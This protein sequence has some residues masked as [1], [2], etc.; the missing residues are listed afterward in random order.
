MEISRWSF[1]VGESLGNDSWIADDILRD[2]VT[3][4]FCI[5]AI[6]RGG[7][8]IMKSLRIKLTITIL[9]VFFIALSALGGLNYWK[10]RQL[11]MESMQENLMNQTV[12][13]ADQLGLWIGARRSEVEIMANSPAIVNGNFETVVPY[14][15]AFVKTNNVYETMSYANLSGAMVDATGWRGNIANREYFQQALR[16]EVALSVP[17]VSKGSGKLISVITVPVKS[18]GKIIGVLSG[19]IKIEDIAKRVLAIKVGQ[20]GYAYV[21]QQDGLIIIH[22]DQEVAMKIN[23]VNDEKAPA[24]IVAIAQRMVK[25]ES[26]IVQSAKTDK[27][28]AFA[29]LP[30]TTWSIGLDVSQKEVTNSIS[31]LATISLVTI[32]VGLVIVAFVIIWYAYRITKPIKE[33]EI[34][35]KQIAGGNIAMNKLGIKSNDEIGRLGQSFE[36]MTETLRELVRRIQGATTQ[37][38]ASSEELTAS[39]EQAAE[40]ANQV[41]IAITETAQRAGQQST[42][43]TKAVDLVGIIVTSAQQETANINSAVEITKQAVAVAEEGNK[44]VDTAINQMNQIQVSVNDSA[45]VVSELGTQSHEIGKIVETISNIAGQTNLLALNAAIEAARA[46]EYGRGFAVVAE[47]VRKLA[48]NSGEAAKQIAT[49][50]GD[51]QTKTDTAVEAMT[52]GMEEVRKGT[53][54]VDKA[55]SAFRNIMEQVKEV[56]VIAHGVSDGLT[57]L[58]DNSGHVLT[59]VKEVDGSSGEIAS[60]AQNISAATEEQLASMEEVASSSQALAKLSEEL[61]EAVRQFKL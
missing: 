8:D 10:S 11:L 53:A 41:A 40:A 35:A 1:S 46:G 59:A 7:N 55:G 24:E 3:G 51:V 47:E 44:A 52:N 61:Q 48:E 37:V 60:Q 22:P 20:T 56:A 28:V 13:S 30:G 54:V 14:L 17:V 39:S 18:E 21:V 34:A 19:V 31:V 38:A 36:Q 5:I 32:I 50:I 26:G 29:P 45:K 42:A 57:Q 49:L 2:L 6:G 27:V 23:A 25:G 16:G 12:N 43:A 33:L 9:A 15:Q 4:Q 58:A